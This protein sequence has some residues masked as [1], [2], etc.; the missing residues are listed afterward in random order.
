MNTAGQEKQRDLALNSTLYELTGSDA[1]DSYVD[2]NVTCVRQLTPEEKEKAKAEQQEK[3]LEGV[4]PV[5][6]FFK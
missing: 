1:D 2:L 3:I 4:P 5:R 6:V